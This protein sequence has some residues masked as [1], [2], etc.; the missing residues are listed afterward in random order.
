MEL[1]GR[2][3]FSFHLSENKIF[4]L[5]GIIPIACD[6]LFHQMADSST[7]CILLLILS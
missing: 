5:R 3:L 4:F 6:E 1:I 7:V 2:N